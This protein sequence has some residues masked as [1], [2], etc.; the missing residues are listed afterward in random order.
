M[1][2]TSETRPLSSAHLSCPFE[3]DARLRA[4]APVYHEPHEDVWVVS[5]YEDVQEALRRPDVFSNRFGRI[6]R[7]RDRLPAEALDI[8]A[9]GWPPVD[10]LFTTDPPEH[11][12]FRALVSKAFT[13][14]R[15]DRMTA[16][17]DAVTRDLLASMLAAEG[18]V[19]VVATFAGPLPMIVI[20]DQLGVSRDDLDHF[21]EWSEAVVAEL[22]RLATPEVQIEAARACVAFQRYFHAR[23]EE[24]RAAATDD[25]LSDLVHAETVDDRPLDDRELL[26]MLQQLLVAGNETTTNG[27]ASG[28]WHLATDT[29]LQASLRAEPTRIAGFV[30]E[31]LR[32]EAPVQGMWRIVTTDVEL[33]GVTLPRDAVVMLR[34][35]S[36]NRD[37]E[38]YDDPDDLDPD[39]DSPRDH[40]AFGGGLHFCIGAALARSEME[41]AFGRLLEATS[42]FE[43]APDVTVEHPAHMLVRGI[44][45]LPVLLHSA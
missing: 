4:E 41:I 29:G 30:E 20:A 35:G 15:V 42:S 9:E 22:S 32:L 14:R 5:R 44:S 21:S 23:I 33:G 18:P 27:I 8:L 25:I 2:Q 26:M 17:I 34:Y 6:I 19:D 45:E 1:E 28:V 3:L 40:L 16:E 24:R 10:T 39:R 12:R 7:S 38:H 37:S 36:A 31:I 43:L 13:P 11:R